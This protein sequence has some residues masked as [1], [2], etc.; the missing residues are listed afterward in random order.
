MRTFAFLALLLILGCKHSR[1]L[2]ADLVKW[3]EDPDHGLQKA[4]S[5]GDLNIIAQYRP[6]DYIIANE[7][8][9]E[10]PT[11]N[12]LSQRKSELS[13]MEYYQIRL[14]TSGADPLLAGNATQQ[15]YHARNS[16]L[17]FG[18]KDYIYLV[19]DNDTLS[20]HL[21]HFVN[22]Q[23]LAPYADI[24]LGFDAPAKESQST[25][26]LIYDDQLFNLG[27]V[28]FSFTGKEITSVPQLALH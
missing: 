2:P 6:I 20:C 28:H 24:V 23:G 14:K 19:R 22:Y 17:M 21:Y 8:K 11:T 1:L 3:V 16:F 4:K 15:D 9:G 7:L 26:E 13:R 18:Q 27:P 12:W 10:T 5:V 25:R